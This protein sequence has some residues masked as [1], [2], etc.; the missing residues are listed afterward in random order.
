M[1][2]TFLA[3]SKAVPPYNLRL[4]DEL[5]RRG[6]A[7]VPCTGRPVI[8]VPQQLIAH[9]A[10]RYVIGSNGAVIFDVCARTNLHVEAMEKEHV[11]A[12]FERVRHLHVTFDVFADGAVYAQR[13]RFEAMGSYGI[14]EPTLQMLRRVRTPVDLTVAEVLARARSVEKVTC[15]WCDER[16]RVGM[17]RAIQE[18]GTF[19]SAQG[20][21]KNFELQAR[22]VSKGFALKW[23]CTYLQVSPARTVAF[24]DEANDL[25]LLLAAGDGVAMANA[26][27]EVLAAADHVTLRSNDD[28]GVAHYLFDQL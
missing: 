8:A 14:D 13:D 1:D 9:P 2:G 24:G 28:A 26:T 22:G 15:F 19:S 3:A 16:D 20:H 11:L 7:F 6:I 25:P 18:L 5:E 12:L 21:P 17:Q 10:T 4:L 23:L 27:P